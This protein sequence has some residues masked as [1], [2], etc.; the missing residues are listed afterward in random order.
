MITDR[1]KAPACLRYNVNNNS[2][3]INKEF[4]K[5]QQAAYDFASQMNETAII[6]GYMFVKHKG[7]WVRN[8]IFIDHV[9]KIKKEGN[10]MKK[11]LVKTALGY[12]CFLSIEEIEVT[13]PKD[14]KEC[15]IFEEF[16]NS[17]NIKKIALKYTDNKLFHEITNRLIELDKV[18][19]TEEEHAERQA[20][21]TLSQYFRVKF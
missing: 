1:K 9:F 17:T 7:E 11:D 6:R 13:D 10:V 20:L 21:I 5:D 15:K 3:S 19:L 8:T 12:R 16:N 18:D 14:K 4:G 2:G